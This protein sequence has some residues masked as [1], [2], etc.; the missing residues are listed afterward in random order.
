MRRRFGRG[1]GSSAPPGRNMSNVFGPR[2]SPAAPASPVATVL[3]PF[4]ASVYVAEVDG[5]EEGLEDLGPF[6]LFV[7]GG[8]FQEVG[9]GGGFLEVGRAAQG[10]AVGAGD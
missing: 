10:Q 4:G 8:G 7:A 2:V 3:R 5:G 9:D 1:L 6:F